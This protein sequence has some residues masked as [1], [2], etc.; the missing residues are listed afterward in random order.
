MC[1]RCYID[2][3]SKKRQV[4]HPVERICRG[5]FYPNDL[6]VAAWSERYESR[7]NSQTLSYLL[8][9]YGARTEQV[10]RLVDQHPDLAAPLM[11]D[12]PF[13]EAQ[14]VYSVRYEYAK[15]L[16]DILLR[17]TMI[18]IYGDYGMSLLPKVTQILRDHCQW[19]QEKCDRQIEVYKDYMLTHCIPD[20]EAMLYVSEV[21]NRSSLMPT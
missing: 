20:Y 16:V 4:M 3:D 9:I 11:E 15:S 1:W 13:I 14:V 21:R 12:H 8:S 2:D 10:L 17:R 5:Q 7:I 18:A 19:S 6:R